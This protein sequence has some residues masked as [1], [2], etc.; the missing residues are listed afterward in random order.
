MCKEVF[1]KLEN[2]VYLQKC[3]VIMG[4]FNQNVLEGSQIGQ[5]ICNSFGFIQQLTM[6]LALTIFTSIFQCQILLH[7]EH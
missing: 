2:W 6:I 7:M 4:D 1:Q 3:T 5:Y